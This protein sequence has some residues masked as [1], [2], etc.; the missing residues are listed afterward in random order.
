MSQQNDDEVSREV[1][2]IINAAPV[3]QKVQVN[4]PKTNASVQIRVVLAGG[5]VFEYTI[6]PGMPLEFIRGEDPFLEQLQITFNPPKG[7]K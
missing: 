3:G 4:F 6:I 7:L 2:R 5:W 1:A